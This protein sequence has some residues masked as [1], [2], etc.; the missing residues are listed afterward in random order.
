VG[1]LVVFR[2]FVPVAT[3][4]SFIHFCSAFHFQ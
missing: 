2:P 3:V 4:V 1:V